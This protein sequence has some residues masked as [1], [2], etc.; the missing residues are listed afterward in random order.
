MIRTFS[1]VFSSIF[2]ACQ[3]RE[4]NICGCVCL[5]FCLS[6]GGPHVTTAWDTIGQWQVT[7]DCLPFPTP[8]HVLTYSLQ[9]PT[10]TGPVQNCSLCSSCICRQVDGWHSTEMLSC[11]YDSAVEPLLYGHSIVWPPPPFFGCGGLTTYGLYGLQFSSLPCLLSFMCSIIWLECLLSI[12]V[13]LSSDPT[14]GL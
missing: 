4:G 13:V 1:F 6:M 7:W 10:S 14:L 3:Q 5:S 9:D 2:T 12:L 11:L 8:S